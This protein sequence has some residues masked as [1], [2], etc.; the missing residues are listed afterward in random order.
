M[1]SRPKVSVSCGAQCTKLAMLGEEVKG[2][3]AGVGEGSL[4]PGDWFS[5]EQW[6]VNK[7]LNHF[8]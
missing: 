7:C 8:L 3:A 5:D 2:P 1:T 4:P 6:S